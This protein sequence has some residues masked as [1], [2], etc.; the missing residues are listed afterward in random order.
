MLEDG[1]NG[2]PLTQGRKILAI[3]MESEFYFDLPLAE[4]RQLLKHIV[5][6]YL[7]PA[8][9]ESNDNPSHYS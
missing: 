8:L 4:R 6:S 5:N 3:L 2:L 9:T 7:N 1:T